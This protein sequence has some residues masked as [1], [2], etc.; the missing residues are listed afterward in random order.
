MVLIQLAKEFGI[1]VVAN[2]CMDVHREKRFCSI[3]SSFNT[4]SLRSIGFIPI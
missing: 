3:E 4:D 2:H 1:K